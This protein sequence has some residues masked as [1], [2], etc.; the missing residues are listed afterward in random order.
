MQRDNSMLTFETSAVRGVS[1][2]IEKLTVSLEQNEGGILSV[3]S[4]LIHS[5]I[6]PSFLQSRPPASYY[7]RPAFE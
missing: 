5:V 1:D 7:G 6:E 3:V 4:I 2:I